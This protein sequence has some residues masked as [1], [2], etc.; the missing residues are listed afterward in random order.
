MASA[1]GRRRSRLLG[2]LDG[3]RLGPAPCLRGPLPGARRA[4][5]PL[6]ARGPQGAIVSRSP[7]HRGSPREL[8]L[9]PDDARRRRRAGLGG[10]GRADPGDRRGRA[11]GATGRRPGGQP[12]PHRSGLRLLP[13]LVA[14]QP[15]ESSPVAPPAWSGPSSWSA[16]SK[17]RR[18]SSTPTSA[19]PSPS[20]AS[21]GPGP[22]RRSAPSPRQTPRQTIS[23]SGSRRN[24]RLGP[25]PHGWR[26]QLSSGEFFEKTKSP[27]LAAAS[28]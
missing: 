24:P 18:D 1:G 10:A 15:C 9:P 21:P 22:G 19:P 3:R 16:G 5:I 17:K 2:R 14:E 28:P 25:S 23:A 6:G 8:L 26:G 13:G 12:A 4:S 7:S 27:A 20:A 11:D